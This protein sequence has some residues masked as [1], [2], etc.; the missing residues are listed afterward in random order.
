MFKARDIFITCERG[1]ELVAPIAEAGLK[2]L[3]ECF[4]Q[5]KDAYPIINIQNWRSNQATYN[6]NGHIIYR[7]HESI[8]WYIMRAQLKA[9]EQGRWNETRKQLSIDQLCHDLSK[10]PYREKYPQLSILLLKHDLYGTQSNGQL[11]N[12]C[13]GV[14]ME[15][16]F[17]IVSAARFIDNDGRLNTEAFKTVLMHEFGHVLGLTESGRA[18]T[19][20]NLGSHCLDELCIMRQRVNGD[21]TDVTQ[22]RLFAKAKGIPP[23]CDDCIELGNAKLQRDYDR[24]LYL[25]IQKTNAQRNV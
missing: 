18:N 8:D 21:F 9:R 16:K 3:M 19:E 22:A 15:Y 6:E 12:Y 13:L 14:G 25:H 24:Q 4:P 23:I 17:C 10:D 2:E 20:E 11:L 7:P 5:Y 1:M